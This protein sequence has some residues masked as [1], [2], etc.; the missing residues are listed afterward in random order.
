MSNFVFFA[1][2]HNE[3]NVEACAKEAGIYI[4]DTQKTIK[5]LEMTVVNYGCCLKL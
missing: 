3:K 4:D 1:L 2:G 5:G